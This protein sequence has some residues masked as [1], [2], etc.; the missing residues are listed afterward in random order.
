MSE[1]YEN[2]SLG[3]DLRH[4]S[5]VKGIA[6][7]VRSLFFIIVIPLLI[8]YLLEGIITDFLGGMLDGMELDLTGIFETITGLIFRFAIYGIPVVIL[9]FF[10]KFYAKGNKGRLL[11]MLI[12]LMY[13]IAWLFLIFEGGYLALSVDLSSLMGEGEG[14]SLGNVD[15]VLAIQGIIAIL[16]GLIL[17]R[18]VI[19]FT[20][21]KSKR[22][23]YLEK[24]WKNQ[25]DVEYQ[26]QENTSLGTDLKNG[27]W[28]RGLL[29]FFVKLI[30]I[31]VIPY[32]I[33]TY[34][35]EIA[36]SIPEMLGEFADML[37]AMLERVYMFGIPVVVLSLFTGSY[38]KGNKGKLLFS[39]VSLTYSIFWLLMIFEL[40][41]LEIPYDTSVLFTDSEFYLTNV[42]F[43][44]SLIVIFLGVILLKMVLAYNSYMKNRNKYLRKIEEES[45]GN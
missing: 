17:I 5:W 23:K 27:S 4:G 32:V 39:I 15:L 45:D 7:A 36:E 19:A 31:V 14:I 30:F 6:G 18:M 42:G 26:P 28:G 41:A 38:A 2:T 24:F 29:S 25:K 1:E 8:V 21:Y 34:Y 43:V 33:V 44:W 11:F 10:V 13:S 37:V 22:E 16:V 40:G 35:G 3:T 20:S 12:Y 9:T